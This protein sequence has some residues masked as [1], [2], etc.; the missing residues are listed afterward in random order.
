MLIFLIYALTIIPLALILAYKIQGMKQLRVQADY[1]KKS[2]DDMDEQAKLIVRTDMELNKIQEELDKKI[3]GLYAIQRLSRIISMTLEEE[4]IFRRIQPEYLEE[5]GF[6]KAFGFQWDDVS[7]KFVLRFNLGYTNEEIS[8][9]ESFINT[10]SQYC[11]DFI[12]GDKTLSSISEPN[13]LITSQELN[14]IFKVNSF[15]VAPLAPQQ[16][17]RGL[18]FVGT[19]NREIQITEGD[20]ELIKILSTQLAQALENA[21]LFEKTWRNQQELEKK[22]VERT[23]ALSAALEEVKRMSD[24]K[25]NFVSNVSH[26]LR[27]PLTSIKGYASIL[28]AEKLGPLPPAVKE[29][30]AKINLHSDELIHMVNDLLDIARIEAGKTIMRLEETDIKSVMESAADLIAIQCKN[31]NVNLALEVPEN[32]PPIMLDRSQIER[33]FINLLGNAVK[34]TPAQGTITVRAEADEETLRVGVSDTGIGISKEALTKL[35]QEFYRVDNEINQQVKGT[36]LGLSLV[37]HIVEAHK[38]T[39]SVESEPNKG[40]T[41]SFTLPLKS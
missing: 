25:S 17:N 19:Q 12:T 24:H 1:L 28:L 7:K 9:I 5:L 39:I 34:F 14:E 8:P 16:N 10:N 35:F 21:R 38:G 41:F 2:L 15:I 11:I 26:E 27:T 30:I 13:N 20:E 22:V 23:S 18:I 37:K 32:I 3:S 40:S 31:K 36:G 6:E 33:V 4:Q 29:R